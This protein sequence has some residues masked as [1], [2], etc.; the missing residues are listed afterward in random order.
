[1]FILGNKHM[2]AIDIHVTSS[3]TLSIIPPYNR[4]AT[5]GSVNTWGCFNIYR[6]GEVKSM[7]IFLNLTRLQWTIAHCHHSFYLCDML[8]LWFASHP[9][10][11]NVIQSEPGNVQILQLWDSYEICKVYPLSYFQ[12]GGVGAMLISTSHQFYCCN[13]K[14]SIHLHHHLHHHRE[15]ITQE[16]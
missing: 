9:V 1:M 4:P 5:I 6:S 12:L 10:S 14:Y 3:A 15:A 13:Q 2:Y 11:I 7:K 8:H 16:N